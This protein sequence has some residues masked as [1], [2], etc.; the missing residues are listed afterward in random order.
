MN[1]CNK[2]CPTKGS[3]NSW[4]LLAQAIVLQA[5]Q[6]YRKNPKMRAEVTRF[7]RSQYFYGLTGAYGDEIVKRLHDEVHKT[8]KNKR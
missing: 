4:K 8:N 1:R 6:D 3:G 5:V 7:L 2:P